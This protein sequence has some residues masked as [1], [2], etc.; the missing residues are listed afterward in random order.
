MWA[1][2]QPEDTQCCMCCLRPRHGAWLV[3]Q[4]VGAGAVT[5]GLGRQPLG[6]PPAHVL[7]AHRPAHRPPPRGDPRGLDWPGPPSL[8]VSL[9]LGPRAPWGPLSSPSPLLPARPSRPSWS[10][11]VS[12]PSHHSVPS[13]A[14]LCARH[15]SAGPRAALLSLSTHWPRL[16]PHRHLPIRTSTAGTEGDLPALCPSSRLP[17]RGAPSPPPA[18]AVSAALK[19]ALRLVW[20]PG[21]CP[22]PCP[23]CPRGS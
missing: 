6:D 10:V 5:R 3:C 12:V 4:P 8:S 22:A 7:S 17:P 9:S 15:C 11:H 13:P 1:R 19:P 14:R 21:T 18:G 20:A 23:L 16:L 2:V